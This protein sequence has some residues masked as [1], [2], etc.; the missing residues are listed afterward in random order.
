MFKLDAHSFY[1]MV[2]DLNKFSEL[3]K[4]SG[5]KEKKPSEKVSQNFIIHLNNNL[6]KELNVLECT[7]TCLGIDRLISD[8]A[9]D[10]FTYDAFHSH[11]EDINRRLEDELSAACVYVLTKEKFKYYSPPAPLFGESVH[12]LF[13]KA[14]VDISDAGQCLAVNKGTATVF[15]LMRV[16]EHG[17]RALAKPLKIPYAPSWESYLKQI[18]DKIAEKH[19]KKTRGWK[20]DELFFKDLAGDLTTIKTVWRNT[21]MHIQRHY[22]PEEAGIIFQAVK[23]FMQRLATRFDENGKRVSSSAENPLMK[24]LMN[25]QPL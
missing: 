21:T 25:P 17:L 3:I 1:K 6:K 13:N 5:N 23:A 22:S 12:N 7:I 10:T 16:M 2:S 8:L 11:I 18:N 15:H 14:S 4:H 24:G 19:D 9:K 20:K